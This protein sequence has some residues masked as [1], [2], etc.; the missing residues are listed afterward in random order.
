MR[1][2]PASSAAL[3]VASPDSSSLCSRT[4]MGIAPSPIAR[5]LRSPIRLC[6][7][8]VRPSRWYAGA[9]P[10]VEHAYPDRSLEERTRPTGSS[11]LGAF[12]DGAVDEVGGRQHLAQ[13]APVV[14]QGHQRG[15]DAAHRRVPRH[16]DLLP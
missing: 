14:E 16:P 15:G 7:M 6:C 3:I 13:L 2:T 1:F 12:P 4:D 5:T 10:A 9:L 8:W 11:R